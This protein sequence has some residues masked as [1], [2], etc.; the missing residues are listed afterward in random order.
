MANYEKDAP[1]RKASAVIFSDDGGATW[2][3]GDIGIPNGGE[4]IAAELSDGR[5]MLSALNRDFFVRSPLIDRGC[6]GSA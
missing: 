3:R 6:L 1:L 4:S 5:V 2:Q